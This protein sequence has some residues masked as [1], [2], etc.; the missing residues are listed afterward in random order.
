MTGMN[1]YGDLANAVLP[2]TGKILPI[3]GAAVL[4]NQKNWLEGWGDTV[5]ADAV[6]GY[7]PGAQW[8]HTDGDASGALYVNVGTLASCD[9][10]ALLTWKAGTS[11]SPITSATVN[12][13]FLEYHFKTSATSGDNRGRYL[14]FQ[15]SGVGGGGDALRAFARVNDVAVGNA[16]G[17]HGSL[18]L[19]A[20]G[21]VTGLG[22][23]MR[24]TLHIPDYAMA[25][26]TYCA[27]MS[28]LWGD[29]SSSDIS[30]VTRH[31]IHRFGLGG[32]GTGRATANTVF[33]FFNI[34]TGTGGLDMIKTDQHAA[35]A[36]DGLRCIVNGAVKYIMLA[37]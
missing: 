14:R 21:S 10:D 11:G 12:K 15:M 8:H 24:A 23:G 20:S 7:S 9:F 36:T 26:G 35:A 30:G 31:S 18:V 34:T 1:I 32:D 6:A 17:I 19:G 22:V 25:G 3:S 5:P 27:G 2:E 29:G 13:R 33:E 4:E 16:F 28:E 37:D